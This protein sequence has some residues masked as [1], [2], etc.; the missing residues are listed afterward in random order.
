MVFGK[1][2]TVP[3][4]APPVL[5]RRDTSKLPKT[6]IVRFQQISLAKTIANN[7]RWV[8]LESG[9]WFF[10]PNSGK[11]TPA[12]GDPF[13]TSLPEK[14]TKT[15]SRSEVDA[16]R[17]LVE[18]GFAE[19]PGYQAEPVKGGSAY[20]VTS[21]PGGKAKERIFVGADDPVVATLRGFAARHAPDSESA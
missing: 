7:Y 19:G 9:D 13:D 12:S 4:D 21:A 17:N 15:L 2:A 3:K 11:D 16:V 18:G 5:K 8:L 1:A 10:A 14:P 20:V 6:A